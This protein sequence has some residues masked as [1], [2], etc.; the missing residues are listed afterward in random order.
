MS[1]K[2]RLKQLRNALGLS[3]PQL[4]AVTGIS[5][6]TI[7]NV[8]G[9]YQKLSVRMALDLRTSI[10]QTPDGILRTVT[11]DSPI[12]SDES[13][14]RID[15]LVTGEGEPFENSLKTPDKIVLSVD[16]E[17]VFLP[18]NQNIRFF[19]ITDDSMSPEFSPSEI[20]AVDI[21]NIDFKS[22]DYLFLKFN[23]EKILRKV[24]KIESEKVNLVALNEKAVPS[25]LTDTDKI[26]ILGRL[27]YK[28]TVF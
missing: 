3:Q 9:G 6:H 26:K 28:V 8:E 25:I 19:R 2:D 14:L 23:E 22:G 21:Q 5:T 10:V 4:A 12:K 24:Y 15:W 18:K 1:G 13:K 20:I 7:N 11:E 16:G 17:T 27:I